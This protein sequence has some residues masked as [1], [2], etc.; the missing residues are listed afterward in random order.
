MVHLQH[1]VHHFVCL[2]VG[3]LLLDV[4]IQL[5]AHRDLVGADVRN[6]DH[7]HP[8][9]LYHREGQQQDGHQQ[10]HELH[11][12]AEGQHLFIETQQGVKEPVRALL[13]L[14]QHHRAHGGHHGQGD[15]QGGHQ[16]VGDGHG[17]GEHELTGVAGGEDHGQKDADGG[18]GGRQDRPLHLPCAL[19]RSACRINAPP[20]ETV[21]VLNDHDGVIHQHTDAQSQTGQRHDV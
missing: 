17:E 3:V 16:G 10:G 6:H 15:Q 21:N 20:S 12:Q 19:H 4:I 1:G 18:E 7:A 5:H 11:P 13:G 14:A 8:D 9:D 2:L